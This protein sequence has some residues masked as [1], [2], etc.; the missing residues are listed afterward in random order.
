MQAGARHIGV[1]MHTADMPHEEP[2][3]RRTLRGVVGVASIR[4][5]RWLMAHHP[6]QVV[7][8][9]TTTEQHS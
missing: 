6:L 5:P 7:Y 4:Q 8:I 3:H 2:K 1:V 9:S